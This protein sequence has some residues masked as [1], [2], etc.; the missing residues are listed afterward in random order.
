MQMTRKVA[1]MGSVS[2]VALAAVAT[3]AHAQDV[4]VPDGFTLS[5][6]GGA[7]F[8][9][10]TVAEDKLGS[11]PSGGVVEIQ[12]NVGYRAAIAMGKQ[13]DPFWDLRVV[14]AINQQLTST[15]TYS[16]S[17]AGSGSGGGFFAY[18]EFD[19]DFDYETL[20]FEAGYR[21]ELTDSFDVRL[22]AGLRG[23]HYKDSMD[24]TGVQGSAGSGGPD[25]IG[26]ESNYSEDFF[27]VGPRIGIE[28]SA[29]LGD[30]MFGVS[31]MLAG[32]AIFGVSRYESEV[33][34]MGSGGAFP[35]DISSEEESKTVINLE[36]A[37][38][39]DM[40]VNESTTVTVGYRAEGI[41]GLGYSG[42]SGGSGSGADSRWSHGPTLKLTG[43]FD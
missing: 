22:F 19:T 30:S 13:I 36:A 31:G 25:K 26:Y 3:A 7:M 32:A 35:V 4:T 1:L 39:L 12:D 23:L 37:L 29:P 33:T 9:T 28:A 17:S 14:G 42:S 41:M 6:E 11:A 40:H 8:G 18:G 10:N 15:S 20:D 34:V 43:Y 16:A 2:A 24:K 27:G 5:I 38:G 21:P